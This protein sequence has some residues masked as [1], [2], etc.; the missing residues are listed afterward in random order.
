MFKIIKITAVL[1]AA[2]LFVQCA[3]YN[4]FC[5]KPSAYFF[6]VPRDGVGAVDLPHVLSYAVKGGVNVYGLSNDQLR[7]FLSALSILGSENTKSPK[8][9]IFMVPK[10][11]LLSFDNKART[12]LLKY[13][14]F[15]EL[16]SSVRDA[17]IEYKVEKTAVFEKEY[18]NLKSLEGFIDNRINK[19]IDTGDLGRTRLLGDDLEEM[20]FSRSLHNVRIYF[21]IDHRTHT[22]TL[23]G[24]GL[25]SKNGNNQNKDI[26]KS[27]NI[28]NKLNDEQPVEDKQGLSNLLSDKNKNG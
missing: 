12:A 22:I 20:K 26:N 28:V 10:N 14:C 9:L 8:E 15:K 4:L 18:K 24:L 5:D 25:A 13:I 11:E 3:D 7:D 17:L 2:S 27:K 16:P 6:L 1:C 21:T 19:L 23:T